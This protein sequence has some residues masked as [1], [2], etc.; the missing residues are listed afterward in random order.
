[1]LLYHGTDYKNATKIC[2]EKQTNY[3]GLWC[4]NDAKLALKYGRHLIGIHVKEG[5]SGIDVYPLSTGKLTD[6]NNWRSE[7]MELFIAPCMEINCN[8]ILQ[9]NDPVECCEEIQELIKRYK[10]I[11]S[12]LNEYGYPV[13]TKIVI[14]EQLEG[15]I[16][17]LE[18]ILYE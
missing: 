12:N 5:S 18:K 10:F 2:K 3:E 15:V 14:K 6:T 17:D 8:L 11:I 13:E 9:T 1:M 7:P 16:Y 4:T